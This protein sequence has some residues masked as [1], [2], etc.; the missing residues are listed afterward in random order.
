MKAFKN[1]IK[2]QFIY[3][4][5]CLVVI[6]CMTLNA[7]FDGTAFGKACFTFGGVIAILQLANPMAV[8]GFISSLLFFILS[9]VK[10]SKKAL[11]YLIFSPLVCLFFFALAMSLYS[12]RGG[13][14]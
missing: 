11:L 5:I 12:Q 8:F 1:S 10:K 6:V 3:C 7:I 4:I 14:I 2:L 13:V 9:D